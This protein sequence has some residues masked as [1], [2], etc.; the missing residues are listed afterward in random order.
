MQRE[1]EGETE[2][3]SFRRELSVIRAF[4]CAQAEKTAGK[5]V[6]QHAQKKVLCAN[7][8]KALGQ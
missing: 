3:Q 8:K 5:F 4:M 7:I 1:I 6:D 2:Q